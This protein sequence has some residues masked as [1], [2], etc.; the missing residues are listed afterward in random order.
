MCNCDIWI[1]GPFWYCA[2]FLLKKGKIA[3]IHEP[4]SSIDSFSDKVI[5]NAIRTSQF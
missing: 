1:L 3:L 2:R 5:Q 4:T